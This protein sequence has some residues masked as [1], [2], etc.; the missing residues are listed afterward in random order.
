MYC[1]KCGNRI[2][3]SALFCSFCGARVGAAADDGGSAFGAGKTVNEPRWNGTMPQENSGRV[4]VAYAEP[5]ETYGTPAR[6]SGS[7]YGTASAE[8]GSRVSGTG[9]EAGNGYSTM[10]TVCKVCNGAMEISADGKYLVCPY[11]GAKE[12]IIDPNALESERIKAYHDLEEQRIRS[13][14][15][16]ERERIKTQARLARQQRHQTFVNEFRD[17]QKVV[18]VRESN[19]S[20]KNRWIA[21]G[22]SVCF[23]FAGIHRFYVGKIGTGILWMLT[24]GFFGIGWAVDSLKCLFGYF[25]DCEGK[26]LY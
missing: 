4:S 6:E 10:H 15:Q 11:C 7:F 23:G 21:T 2:D 20:R 14:E 25:K 3:D 17:G 8:N 1:S 26:T 16:I 12:I 19:R 13:Q 22:L 18:Y 24:G 9:Y 5:D